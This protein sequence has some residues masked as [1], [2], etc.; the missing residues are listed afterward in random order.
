MKKNTGA[1]WEITIDGTPRS[2]RDDKRLAIK[3]AEYLKDRNSQSEVSRC[4]PYEGIEL[5]I[6]IKAYQSQVKR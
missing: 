3:G 1:R 5:P 6:A 2:Y 4:G